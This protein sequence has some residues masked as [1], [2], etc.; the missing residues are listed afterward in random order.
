MLQRSDH[1]FGIKPKRTAAFHERDAPKVN[2]IVNRAFRRTDELGKLV[3]V[4]QSFLMQGSPASAPGWSEHVKLLEGIGYAPAR[5]MKVIG[6][7][8]YADEFTA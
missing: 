8:F 2:E 1:L 6:A 7:S 3:D 4:D 5:E